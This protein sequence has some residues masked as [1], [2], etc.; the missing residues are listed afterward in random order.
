[1]YLSKISNKQRRP[2]QERRT[3]R[4]D[5]IDMAQPQR[6]SEMYRGTCQTSTRRGTSRGPAQQAAP[7][8]KRGG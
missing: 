8:E 4:T 6:W 7:Q 3:N 1:M 2:V 5:D